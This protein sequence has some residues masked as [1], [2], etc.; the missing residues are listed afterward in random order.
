MEII[1]WKY[2]KPSQK[3][4]DNIKFEDLSK[5]D[6]IAWHNTANNN[7]IYVNTDYHMDTKSWLWLGYGYYIRDGKI[8]EVRGYQYQNAGVGGHNN[9]II[10]CVIEGDYDTRIPSQENIE[11]AIWLTKYLKSKLASI[12]NVE[13]HNFWNNTICPGKLFPI[14]L[15]QR[16]DNMLGVGDRGVDV[17]EVQQKLSQIGY[18]I[19]IDGIFGDD[20]ELYL[21]DFQRKNDLEVNGIVNDD[22]KTKIDN[23]IKR[24][25][26][27]KSDNKI[28]RLQNEIEKL[29][30]SINNLKSDLNDAGF[31]VR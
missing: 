20:T 25:K 18:G 21:K 11:C 29:K 30:V 12:V 1:P 22:T 6:S 24:M 26:S 10:S 7:N 8:Y 5:I 17:Q 16:G 14:K 15:L 4:L 9:H 27:T 31:R 19:V 3:L 2:R 23:M 13:G 28:D